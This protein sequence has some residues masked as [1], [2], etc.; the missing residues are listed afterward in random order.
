MSEEDSELSQD[1]DEYRRWKAGGKT[2]DNR[3]YWQRY[4]NL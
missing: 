2:D 4:D 3:P 1:S